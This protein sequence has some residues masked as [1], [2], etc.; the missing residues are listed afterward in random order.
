MS[1]VILP[2]QVCCTLPLTMYGR[3]V[4]SYIHTHLLLSRPLGHLPEP[5]L[6]QLSGE[7]AA[8][9]KI[10]TERRQPAV[11]R[12]CCVEHGQNPNE[13]LKGPAFSG[14]RHT[15]CVHFV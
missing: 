13:S 5:H 6:C 1:C 15:S 3:S 10:K 12:S 4:T 11:Y 2:Q 7:P 9:E 8:M 14:S